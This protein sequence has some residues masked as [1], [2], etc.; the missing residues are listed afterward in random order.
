MTFT[1]EEIQ[2]LPLIISNPRFNTY[3]L[4]TNNNVST[5]LRLYQWNLQISSA[6]IIPLQV[7]EIAARNGVV[8]ALE[9][10]YGLNWHLSDSFIRS[11]PHPKYG[12]SPSIDF[13]QTSDKLS[14]RHVLTEGKIVAD[15]KFAFWESMLTKRHDTRLWKPY[16]S[17]AFPYADNP[18]VHLSRRKINQSLGQ[19]RELRNRIAHHEPIFTRNITEEYNRIID[20]IGYRCPVS[21]DWVQK[22]QS[23]TTINGNKP[24][25]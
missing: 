18:E 11:L 10:Q 16:F 6:F 5:A 3:M 14:R 21:S 1:S 19:V 24:I 7:C 4:A 22:I 23:V 12:Y 8:L 13:R 20:I 2:N 17:K 25:P 15:L 9:R